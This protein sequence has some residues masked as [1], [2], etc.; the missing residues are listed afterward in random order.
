MVPRVCRSIHASGASVLGVPHPG[1]S[2]GYIRI[3]KPKKSR[4][5]PKLVAGFV[6]AF[7]GVAIGL[8]TGGGA[9]LELMGAAI[10]GE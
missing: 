5:T 7:L 4:S 8:G 9:V 2:V 6:L 10:Y 3:E 1:M